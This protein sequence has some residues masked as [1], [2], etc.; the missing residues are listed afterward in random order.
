M[1]QSQAP[2]AAT[3]QSLETYSAVSMLPAQRV[4]SGWQ[5]PTTEEH[6]LVLL[7]AAQV[8]N[9]NSTS[10]HE[11]TSVLRLA[12]APAASVTANISST[13]AK[14]TDPCS[15]RGVEQCLRQIRAAPMTCHPCE[16]ACASARGMLAHVCTSMRSNAPALAYAC[17]H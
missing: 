15:Q 9:E 4:F 10:V 13:S 3:A 14:Q 16:A 17:M 11:H 8:R 2:P 6:W 1:Q 7:G 12:S 5:L